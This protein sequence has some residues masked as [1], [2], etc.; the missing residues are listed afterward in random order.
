MGVNADILGAAVTVSM[1][2]RL[3]RRLC[4]HCRESHVIEGEDKKTMDALLK[5]IPHPEG[6]PENRDTMWVAKGC[7][8]CGGVGYKG[9]IGVVEVILM[10]KEM[11]QAVRKSSSERDLWV[12]SAH[13]NI[14]RMAQ[15][16][17]V[18]VLQGV[19]SLEELSR[20]VDLH[21]DT[22]FIR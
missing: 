7:P 14:R 11:E 15:D 16:G 22:L 1:A 12:A 9:R 2:Q 17:A 6:V 20:I 4:E 10:D 3:V 21:D 13:Q 8:K 5:N 19:T 18:K